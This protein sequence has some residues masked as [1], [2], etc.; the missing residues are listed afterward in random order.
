[1]SFHRQGCVISFGMS[2][3]EVPYARSSSQP[4]FSPFPSTHSCPHRALA[5]PSSPPLCSAATSWLARLAPEHTGTEDADPHRGD[6]RLLVKDA[7]SLGLC[8]C[9]RTGNMWTCS[10][11]F[12]TSRRPPLFQTHRPLYGCIARPEIHCGCCWGSVGRKCC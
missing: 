11:S 9:D 12:A 8:C 1:M 6:K 5:S 4:S 3:P 10:R 7:R 2:V